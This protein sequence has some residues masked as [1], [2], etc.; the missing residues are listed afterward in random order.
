MLFE[1]RGRDVFAAT[2]GKPFD[3]KKPVVVFLHGSALDH[4]FWG[5][6]TRFFAFRGYAV[7]APDLPGHTHSEGPL[8]ESIEDMAD[9]L[10]DVVESLE[11]D[12]ISL[13]AH[14]QGCLVALEFAARFPD[15]LRSV[16]FI[17]SGLATPVNPALIDS[18]ENDPE[19]A[20]DMMISWGFGP[21]GHLHQGPI[22]GG[23]MM[24]GGRR[25]MRGNVPLELATDLRACDAYQNGAAAAAS[26]RA[27]VQVILGGQDR[28]APA[29]A[30]AELVDA[31]KEP[32]VSLLEGCGHM[33]PLEAP[34]V[35]RKLLKDFVFHHNPAA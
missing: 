11:I 33:V 5:L 30:T 15:K 31:L 10:N 12:N 28:M 29:R 27:P 14:S 17:A 22:P 9:W 23:S 13:V 3:Q 34:N 21:A 18:A 25:V 26:I 35:C 1:V 8:L 19:A 16:S 20:I 4:T 32:Q 6:Y 24:A 7:L 2:G